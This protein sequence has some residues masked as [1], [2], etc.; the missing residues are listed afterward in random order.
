MNAQLLTGIC[1]ALGGLG[2]WN[3]WALY[4]VQQRLDTIEQQENFSRT[5]STSSRKEIR[6]KSDTESYDRSSL[7]RTR[8]KKDMSSMFSKN[9]NPQA[10]PDKKQPKID[11]TDPD[12]QDA[13]AKI[14]ETNAQEKEERRRK[15]KMEAY[16]T[17]V[18]HELEKFSDEK[19]YDSD[20]L[21]SIESILD[22][23]TAEWGDIRAQVRDGEISWLDA[24]TE[25]KAI[26]DETEEKVTEF[27]SAEDYKELRTRLWGDR[28]R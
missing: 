8:K 20:T 10:M 13:I 18:K 15:S 24:R 27:I 5:S 28:G 14:A 9:T 21:Q 3:A 7:D 19:K 2:T 23:S 4:Q 17:S 25:F 12:I 22:E 6:S 1:L 16:K 11:L 26:G